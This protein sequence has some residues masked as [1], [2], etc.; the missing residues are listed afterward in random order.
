MKVLILIFTFISL[1]GREIIEK[2][3]NRETPDSSIARVQMIITDAH[4][5]E[6]VRVI[7]TYSVEK[8]GIR[9]TLI[10]FI[11]PADVKG[12]E[13][14][15]IENLKG[16]DIQFL[17]LSALKRK[18]RIPS[19]QRVSSFMGSDFS[20]ADFESR[21]VE[22]AEH[23]L[24]REDR[25]NDE[26]VYIVES[27][28][29][30]DPQY[31]KFVQWIRKKDYVPIR[32]DFYDKKGELLKRLIAEDIKDVDGYPTAMKTTMMN[33]QRSTKTVLKVLKVKNNVK[34]PGRFFMPENLGKF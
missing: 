7:E 26:E 8:K 18:R 10:K 15:H 25:F 20:Y 21:N 6:R 28:P 29:Y 34:I 11:E 27:I 13:F 19:S 22:Q 33:L 16:E 30:N 24:L 32:I 12:T 1:T 9:K 4:G 3:Y 17:Y 31:S 14:L 23:R 2:T 5:K